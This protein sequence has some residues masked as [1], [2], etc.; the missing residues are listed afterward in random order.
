M[1]RWVSGRLSAIL[2]CFVR[3]LVLF[4]AAIGAAIG[5]RSALI[6]AAVEVG[7]STKIGV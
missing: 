5:A 6:A 7:I 4:L 2:W 1:L 3:V